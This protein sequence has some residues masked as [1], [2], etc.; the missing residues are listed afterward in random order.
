MSRAEILTEPMETT[1]LLDQVGRDR[2]F[3]DVL[4]AASGRIT[5]CTCCGRL[6]LVLNDKAGR[7]FATLPIKA[8][9]AGLMAADLIDAA[10]HAERIT[11]LGVGQHKH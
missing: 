4:R 10:T 11:P 2:D 5:V 7:V 8:E 9:H 3:G 6:R 1:T